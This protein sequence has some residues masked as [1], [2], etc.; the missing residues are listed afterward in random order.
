MT[1]AEYARAWFADVSP[2][3]Q[4]A[5]VIGYGCTLANHLLPAFGDLPLVE[6]RRRELRRYVAAKRDAGMKQSTLRTHIG[7]LS[8]ILSA[9]VSDDELPGNPAVGFWRRYKRE[10]GTTDEPRKKAIPA[11]AV[12]PF[13]ATCAE[14]SPELYALLFTYAGTGARRCEVLGLQAGDVDFERMSLRIERQWVGGKRR[15]SNRTKG[16]KPRDVPLSPRLAEVLRAAIAESDALSER[17]FDRVTEPRW[18]FRSGWTGE[19]WS[20]DHVC[21]RVRYLAR[22][23]GISGV[24][25]KSFRHYVASSLVNGGESIRDAQ[26]I[27]GHRNIATTM[28]YVAPAPVHNPGAVDRLVQTIPTP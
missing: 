11:D 10:V 17:L 1:F 27:L 16:G 19:P 8:A 6:L 26:T 23:A 28:G 15:W 13:F 24:S 9:A 4:P 2:T 25:P 3:L 12:A 7:C 14:V 21:K 20:P 18:I 22:V 5:T